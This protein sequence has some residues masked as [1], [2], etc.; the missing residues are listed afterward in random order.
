MRLVI[1]TIILTML[2]YTASAQTVMYCRGIKGKTIYAD[3]GRWLDDGGS[4]HL[5]LALNNFTQ[6]ATMHRNWFVLGGLVFDPDD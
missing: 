3:E 2:S 6:I 5:V 4:I 1:T